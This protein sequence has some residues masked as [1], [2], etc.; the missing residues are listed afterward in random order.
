[1]PILNYVFHLT[2]II[3]GSSLI[4]YHQALPQIAGGVPSMRPNKALPSSLNCSRKGGQFS[5]QGESRDLRRDTNQRRAVN[6]YWIA[7]KPDIHFSKLSCPKY[8]PSFMGAEN[9]RRKR[10]KNTPCLL[11]K[12]P[13][14]LFRVFTLKDWEGRVCAVYIAGV[15]GCSMTPS[16]KNVARL[17]A[18]T[19]HSS[20]HSY[21][22]SY[23]PP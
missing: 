3:C 5:G 20:P 9:D 21:T 23:P 18:T 19:Q 6:S 8:R 12:L 10:Y 16:C 1:M 4:V 7:D 13:P 22:F 2:T 15:F 11:M 14:A 17:G